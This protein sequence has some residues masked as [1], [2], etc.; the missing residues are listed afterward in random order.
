MNI[1]LLCPDCGSVLEDQHFSDKC[2][3]YI[4]GSVFLDMEC[5][6]C[7]KDIKLKLTTTVEEW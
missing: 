7:S 3:I 1:N 4:D 6:K 5:T 2:A